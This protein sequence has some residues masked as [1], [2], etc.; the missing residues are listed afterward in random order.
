VI[1]VKITRKI[2]DNMLLSLRSSHPFANERVGFLFARK[3]IV[4]DTVTIIPTGFQAVEDSHY[5][6]DPDVG[7]RITSAAI[8]E[9]ME[10]AYSTGESILHV[11]LHEHLGKPIFSRADIFGYSQMVPSFHNIRATG[12]HGGLVFT[13]DGSSGLIWPTKVASP[14]PVN[15][16]TIVGYPLVIQYLGEEIYVSG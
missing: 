3:D 4:E 9:V 1:H 10:R 2:Y 14:V 5:A 16:L 7:A 12:F 11:H 6:D 8:R 13:Q 15:K